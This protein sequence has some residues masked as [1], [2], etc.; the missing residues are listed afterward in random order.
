MKRRGLI[1]AVTLLLPITVSPALIPAAEG[2]A[3]AP[4]MPALVVLV[5]HAEKADDPAG[6]PPLTEAG[7]QRA[8]ALARALEDAG[9]TAIITSD[10]L[11]TRATAEPLAE[12]RG[13][14]P[15]VVGLGSGGV[16]AHIEA[17]AAEVRRHPGEVVVVIG[18]LNTVPAIIAALGG[19]RPPDIPAL[20]YGLLF[21]FVPG[22]GGARLVRAS[23]GAPGAGS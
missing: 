11:R 5:R 16:A 2:A 3:E 20:E 21:L 13:L 18:H 6:D 17:V 23:Y 4:G 1:Q 7:K 8:R 9:V 22:P 12:A 19:P 10:K 15:I 14:T